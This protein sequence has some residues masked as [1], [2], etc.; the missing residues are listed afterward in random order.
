MY[1][2]RLQPHEGFCRICLGAG[3]E[4]HVELSGMKRFHMR[5]QTQ[6]TIAGRRAT[7]T[8]CSQIPQKNR[9]LEMPEAHGGGIGQKVFPVK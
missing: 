7:G 5:P 4:N 1:S 3:H 6:E 8:A 2:D 9:K